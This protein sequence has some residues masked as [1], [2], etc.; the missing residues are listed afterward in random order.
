[1]ASAFTLAV[2]ISLTWVSALALLLRI[3]PTH[4][5]Q[6]TRVHTT[7]PTPGAAAA[8]G[9]LLEREISEQLASMILH[10]EN[11]ISL[12]SMD[13]GGKRRRCI[14][15]LS[16]PSASSCGAKPAGDSW[17]FPGAGSLQWGAPHDCGTAKCD[18]ACCRRNRLGDPDAPH[19]P[20]PVSSQ[21]SGQRRP[22]AQRPGVKLEGEHEVRIRR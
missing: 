22:A 10:D 18:C 2:L 1:M 5:V 13:Q 8:V 16:G 4:S 11:R 7:A 9:F 21:A 15:R 14:A 19:R 12:F 20:S 6:R 17:E 3:A